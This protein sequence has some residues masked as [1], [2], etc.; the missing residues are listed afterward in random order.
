LAAPLWLQLGR[1][2]PRQCQGGYGQ[3]ADRSS[4]GRKKGGSLRRRVLRRVAVGLALEHRINA[5]KFPSNETAEFS[6]GIGIK[7][8]L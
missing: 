8:S 3:A 2:R 1:P 5:G 4:P 7:R 6:V